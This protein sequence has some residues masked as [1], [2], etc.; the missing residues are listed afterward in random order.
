ML[1]NSVHLANQR[2]HGSSNFT[3][4]NIA[5][6]KACRQRGYVHRFTRCLSKNDL[7][8]EATS[9]QRD[10]AEHSQGT[11]SNFHAGM[12]MRCSS[13][14]VLLIIVVFHTAL[15]GWG[16]VVHSPTIDE[17]EWLPGGLASW[18]TGQLDIV[19][20]N[21]PHVGLVAAIPLLFAD[22]N[23]TAFDAPGDVRS[24]GSEFIRTN[25]SRSF[26][27]FTLGRWACIP[28]SILGTIACF[29]WA[30]DLYGP[31]PGLLAATLWCFC[32]NILAHGQL[33]SHDVP[34][35]SLGLIASYAF[36]QW[37]RQSSAKN[38]LL[39][40]LALGLALLTKMTILI[41]LA[42]WPLIWIAWCVGTR[43]NRCLGRRWVIEGAKL[44][45]ILVLALDV[46]N[47][48]YAFQGSFASLDSYSFRSQA[49]GGVA[50]ERGNRFAGSFLGELPVPFPRAFVEGVDFQ[51]FALEGG[52][53]VQASYLRGEW[54]TRG[55]WYYYLYALAIKVPLGTWCLLLLS[56]AFRIQG[57][58]RAH[59]V[60]DE[61]I[62]L[63]PALAILFLASTSP[64]VT[65]HLR[66]VLPCFPFAFIWI[67][68]I[69]NITWGEHRWL[70]GMTLVAA[71][72]SVLSSLS[73]YPHSLS[74]F[75]ELVGGPRYGHYH[76]VSS[77]IDYGQDLLKLKRW[78]DL[79]PEA[80]PLGLAYNDLRSVDPRIAG[81]EYFVAPSGPAPGVPIQR[82]R[83]NDL[84][85][86]PGW[87][88]VNVNALRG[89]EWPARRA[90]PDL[91]F[92]G[93]F[94][95]F[96]PVAQAGYSIYIYHIT[97]DDANRVRAQIGL[98]PLDSTR[99]GLGE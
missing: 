61:V 30:R 34:A 79:H 42:L 70:F 75:N 36:W 29:V 2:T 19:V 44:V 26:W 77:N 91:A 72:W 25:G 6:S 99:G 12:R 88:A 45:A 54:S 97:L 89:D 33:V 68:R 52:L 1:V 49:L 23:T 5:E 62:S 50:G 73:V 90:Y 3:A 80:R 14:H 71:V 37:L 21:P 84:G 83:A 69:A 86:K 64:G 13:S 17:I 98:P 15:L 81:I 93:Y 4:R 82:S 57:V 51:R 46:L 92:Y 31:K 87:Y 20:R 48:G 78:Y 53:P 41:Y 27:L 40:G 11:F 24:I 35:T 38:T 66:Y 96:P 56:V 67:S 16:A 22:P 74:Y 47:L 10:L 18:K 94:L 65:D 85:P 95:N 76:L 28:F 9:C 39:A 8:A 63:T 7:S 32:P 58:D 55:W 59:F 60:R 43:E